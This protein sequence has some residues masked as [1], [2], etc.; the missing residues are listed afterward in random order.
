ML[1][2]ISEFSSEVTSLFLRHSWESKNSGYPNL[3]EF[4]IVE[5]EL[6]G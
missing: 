4:N 5:L 1:N 2:L 6:G 3:Q